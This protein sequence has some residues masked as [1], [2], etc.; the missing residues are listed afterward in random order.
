MNL[1]THLTRRAVLGGVG[2]LLVIATLA[3]C[4]SETA[5]NDTGAAATPSQ[6]ASTTET[7]A[8]DVCADVDT[9]KASLQALVDTNVVQEGTDTLK[10]RFAAL[11]S[12]V[13]TLLE[14]GQAELAPKTAEVKDSIAM[15]QDALAGLKNDPTAAELAPLKT[16]LQAVKT[17]TEDL[18]AAV[19]DTC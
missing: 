5:D 17:S 18:I 14:S 19:E 9:A 7:S 4:S 12:D 13:Q 16:S 10:T 6:S 11:E 8:A 3:G 15:L 2:G 1:L